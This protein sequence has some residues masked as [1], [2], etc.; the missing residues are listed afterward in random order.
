[1]KKSKALLLALCAAALSVGVTFG[2]LAYLTDTEAVVNT[3]TV[4]QVGI[5]LTEAAVNKNGEKIDIT[6]DKQITDA[7]RRTKNEYH[8]LPGHTYFKD[9][10]VTVD[11]DS[12]DAY[13]RMMVTINQSKEWDAIC[14]KYTKPDGTH[15]GILDMFDGYDANTWLYQ[16]NKEDEANNTRTYEFRYKTTA[17]DKSGKNGDGVLEALFTQLKMPGQL[18]NDDMKAIG[19]DFSITVV[20]HA[21]QADGF[22]TADAAW[23]AFDRQMSPVTP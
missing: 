21:I 4:G 3:F 13:I 22:T 5:E 9:P 10:T 19:N 8:L 18:T 1:M 23:T 15:I 2:T 14:A 12:S 17:N 7:D 6:D 11:A 16:G 20:A